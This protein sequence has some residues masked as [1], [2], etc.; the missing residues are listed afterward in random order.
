ML[1]LAG[2]AP[3]TPRPIQEAYQL[4]RDA[5]HGCGENGELPISENMVSKVKWGAKPHMPYPVDQNEE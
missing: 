2:S 1:F 3:T 4:G 5:L